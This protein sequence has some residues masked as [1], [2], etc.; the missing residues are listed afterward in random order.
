MRSEFH[1][2]F[3]VHVIHNLVLPHDVLQKDLPS[4]RLV[5]MFLAVKHHFSE[6]FLSSVHPERGTDGGWTCND[7]G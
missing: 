3:L 7:G 1:L 5:Q 2:K 4:W 6:P